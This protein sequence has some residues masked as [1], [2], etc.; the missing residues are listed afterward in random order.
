MFAESNLAQ[1]AQPY[2]HR[3]RDFIFLANGRIKFATRM[4]KGE[5]IEY[6][7]L[8]LD[9]LKDAVFRFNKNVYK[10]DSIRNNLIKNEEIINLCI[11]DE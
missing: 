5:I 1:L 9:I 2:N 6:E 11:I 3:Y 4:E 8:T 7:Y 10:P